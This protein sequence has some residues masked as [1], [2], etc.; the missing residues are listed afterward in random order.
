MPKKL[1]QTQIIERFN[2]IHNNFYDYSKVNYVNDN[3]KV[4]IACPIHGEFKQRPADHA[5]QKQG[6]PQCGII[7]NTDSKRHGL[8]NFIKILEKKTSKQFV[9]NLDFTEAVYKSMH[10]KIKL[11]CRSSNNKFWQV[12]S[13][14]VKGIC[15]VS[16]NKNK[17]IIK[18]APR[19]TKEFIQKA[20][21]IHGNLYDYS[22]TIFK[23]YKEQV[24]II[25][26]I[27]GSFK[28]KM[29]D[30]I[31]G[32]GCQ[33]CGFS[34]GE[35]CILVWLKEKNIS[36][37]H[38]HKVKIDDS[39][40]WFDVYIPDYNLMVEFQGLQHFSPIKFFG[41]KKYFKILQKKDLQK[42]LYCEKNNINLLTIHYN[43]K[44]NIPQIL[45]QTILNKNTN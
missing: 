27:H 44:K 11:T 26:K 23:G 36:H 38:Q 32:C 41:G 37:H 1:T 40:H 9:E 15:C 13:S 4:L 3:V 6:C 12:P 21:K 39:Y 5:R 28:Q 10:E 7:K 17:H 18:Q 29:S 33:T 43:D 31:S 14:L 35:A 20:K 30:H 34:Q 8:E 22:K 16:C 45:E 19:K 24:D 25:C 2:K 42:K